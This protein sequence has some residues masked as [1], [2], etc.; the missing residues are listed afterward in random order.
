ML[1][2]DCEESVLRLG[3]ALGAQEACSTK[4]AA[5]A[6]RPRPFPGRNPNN[7]RH[8]QLQRVHC[9]VSYCSCPSPPPQEHASHRAPLPERPRAPHSALLTSDQRVVYMLDTPPSA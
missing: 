8:H 1:A 7:W 4:P 6:S 2:V 3:A 5:V 9:M